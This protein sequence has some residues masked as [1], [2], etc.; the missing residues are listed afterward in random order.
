[1]KLKSELHTEKMKE[2]IVSSLQNEEK[3]KQEYFQKI[4]EA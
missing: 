4:K 1:M 2:V 3:K